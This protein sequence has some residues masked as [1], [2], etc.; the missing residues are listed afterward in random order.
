[1]IGRELREGEETFVVWRRADGYV[2]A[3]CVSDVERW[4]RAQA[5][6]GGNPKLHVVEVLLIA[7]KWTSEVVEFIETRR[8]ESPHQLH[9]GTL[10]L[11]E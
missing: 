1:V 6:R 4:Q 2:A 5:T 11:A 10:G 7:P 8:A 9:G 3:S